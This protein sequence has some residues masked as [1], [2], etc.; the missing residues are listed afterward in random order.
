GGGTPFRRGCA[1]PEAIPVPTRC[2]AF[3]APTPPTRGRREFAPRR[4]RRAAGTRR[5][6][7]AS[8]TGKASTHPPEYRRASRPGPTYGLFRG[9]APRTATPSNRLGTGP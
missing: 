6:A 4:G 9:I 2:P 5:A 1:Q 3:A 7:F 8:P